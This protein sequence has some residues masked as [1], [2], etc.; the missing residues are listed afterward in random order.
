MLV[1]IIQDIRSVSAL[2]VTL[3]QQ[4]T[5]KRWNS[6]LSRAAHSQWF[7]LF[8]EWAIPV[9]TW[10][11]A[12]EGWV[13]SAQHVLSSKRHAFTVIREPWRYGEFTVLHLQRTTTHARR[14]NEF[15]CDTQTMAAPRRHDCIKRAT[16]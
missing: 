7:R 14:G 10:Y 13:T 15:R 12:A 4:G 9:Q 3:L 5:R 8:W 16:S 1:S 6:H 2:L 11:F